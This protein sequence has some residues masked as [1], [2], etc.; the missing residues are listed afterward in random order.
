MS[1]KPHQI[2]VVAIFNLRVSQGLKGFPGCSDAKESAA[3]QK[4]QV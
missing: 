3:V 2:Y 1:R 4:I